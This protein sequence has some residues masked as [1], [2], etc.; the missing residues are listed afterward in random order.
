MK[1][2]FISTVILFATVLL[3]QGQT[4]LPEKWKFQTGDDPAF[5]S[6]S[7]N[8]SG[9]ASIVPG[10]V[11]EKQGYSGYDGF[12]WY[13]V[14]FTI[15]SSLKKDAE[16]YGGL[17]LHLGKID[18]CDETFF[19]GKRIGATGSMA[20]EG[21][22]AW[23]TQR[24]YIINSDQVKWGK[25]NTV[26]VRV[27]DSGGDGGIYADPIDLIPKGIS[28][29]V[30]FAPAMIQPDRIIKGSP[31]VEIPVSVKNEFDR[32]L[33]GSIKVY[34]LSDFGDSIASFTKQVVVKKG[35]S[36]T[37]IL[38]VKNI[39]PGFYKVSA[40][41]Q[42]SFATEQLHFNFGY[43]PEKIVS[44]ANP[45]PDFKEFW[46]AAKKELA[47]VDPQYKIIKKD[48]L[49][50]AGHNVYLVEMRSLGNV[51][52]RGW[53]QVPTQP[54]KYPAIMQVPGYSSTIM[55][56]YINYGDDIIGFGLN[57][58]G[59]GNSKVDVNPG[60]PGYILTNLD[61]RDKYIYRGTYM[62]CVRGIDF[63]FSLPEVDT[64]RVGVEGAS[65]GGALTFVTA[66][67]NNTRIA[68][69]VPQ[70]PF[71]SDFPHYFKVASWPG[72]EFTVYVEKD[73][74][75]T[76]DQV[77]TTL[78]Y[79]DIKN[80]ASMIKAPLLMSC[81][82]KDE[83]CPPHINFAAYNNVTGEKSYVAYPDAGHGVPQA[84]YA[85]KMNFFRTKFGL[86]K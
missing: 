76:W 22:T 81:G 53:L 37:V 18:D 47:Q 12:A 69:C 62:D 82:L 11:W 41:L 85:I 15:P 33:N 54:G 46:A 31:D 60:F 79:F 1:K 61:D 44:P 70:V 14:T 3:C 21:I 48:S 28:D 72:N 59:H 65:Q 10:T 27:Y 42:S 77:F 23:D 40:I 50:T 57:V 43:E 38:P 74:K 25:L 2:I 68:A 20:P 26:A 35:K 49:C 39:A 5:A 78:S 66:A 63:L 4:I 29:F 83:T 86:K 80:L 73:K 13:R 52:I 9:W 84:F 58:R 75:Q 71:L 7:F 30:T 17:V 34:I 36:E 32:N 64:T 67:L 19:N 45:Q 16:K 56:E 51:R 24:S 6:P 55:P 8:D